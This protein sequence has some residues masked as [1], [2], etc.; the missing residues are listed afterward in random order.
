MSP[1]IKCIV[2]TPSRFLQSNAVTVARVPASVFV[3]IKLVRFD[4]T[5]ADSVGVIKPCSN[6]AA[7]QL[8]QSAVIFYR[9]V[10]H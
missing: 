4:A 8:T 5:S 10:A 9:V 7:E 1:F 6:D 3:V 2:N